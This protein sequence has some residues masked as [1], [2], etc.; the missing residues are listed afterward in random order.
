MGKPIVVKYFSTSP[1]LS[2]SPS[3][4]RGKYRKR[5]F[6]PLRHPGQVRASSAKGEVKV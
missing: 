6:A 5:G 4:E 1:P 3:K 2:P